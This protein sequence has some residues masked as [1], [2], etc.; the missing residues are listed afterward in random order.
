M[1]PPS[2]CKPMPLSADAFFS[3]GMILI[4]SNPGKQTIDNWNQQTSTGKIK[5]ILSKLRIVI[6]GMLP[7]TINSSTVLMY[8]FEIISI[9]NVLLLS[10]HFMYLIHLATSYFANSDYSVIVIIT[11]DITFY[12]TGPHFFIFHW[13]RHLQLLSNKRYIISNVIYPVLHWFTD[14][15]QKLFVCLFYRNFKSDI[16]KRVSDHT[17]TSEA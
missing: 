15:S 6:D 8:S 16:K 7:R 2:M 5:I 4:I 9:L 13:D 3:P 1:S 14:V 10:L 17:V 12:C 11:P